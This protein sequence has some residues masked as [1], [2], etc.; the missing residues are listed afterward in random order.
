MSKKNKIY[1][2]L[3]KQSIIPNLLLAAIASLLSLL[4][5]EAF[6]H[7][8]IDR[9]YGE[10]SFEESMNIPGK[11]I[12]ALKPYGTIKDGEF[13]TPLNNFGF[14]GRDFALDKKVDTTRIAVIGDSFTFGDGL[15]ND[16]DTFPYLLEAKLNIGAKF[17]VMN[18]GFPGANMMDIY[19]TFIY[20]VLPFSPDIVIY[21][22]YINDLQ[23][24]DYNLDADNCV[25]TNK[26]L[27]YLPTFLKIRNDNLIMNV[28]KSS[29][30]MTNLYFEEMLSPDYEGMKCFKNLLREM[31]G[32]SLEKN[33]SL[34]AFNV[35][36]S[37]EYP[38]REEE[39]ID[40]FFN[41]SGIPA[42]PRFGK[43]FGEEM[44][45]QNITEIN[46]D[47]PKNNHF[48]RHGNSIIAG[49]LHRYL[50]REGYAG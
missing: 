19:W 3:L 40:S 34:I 45:L 37:F 48:N 9:Y 15:E 21:G 50:V 46:V 30:G 39:A 10:R 25:T 22:F 32:I 29:P 17:E 27:L 24:M 31:K 7:I 36:N 2:G 26:R 44:I 28:R 42:I 16:D 38:N 33:I 11:N 12:W 13:N 6:L 18:F 5:L 1:R 43:M 20:R 41:E 47:R 35:P 49:I 4:M 14:R 8:Y 23:F